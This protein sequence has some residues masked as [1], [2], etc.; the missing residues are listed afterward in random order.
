[1][2]FA[3]EP[4]PRSRSSFIRWF[5]IDDF[6]PEKATTS[7][8]MSSKAFF[9]IRFIVALYS[10]IVMWIDIGF[11]AKVGTFQG[12]FAFFTNMT[13]IGL[14]AYLIVSLEMGRGANETKVYIY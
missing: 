11:S 9:A 1:M 2:T 12:F 14:H 10:T 6:I 13:F 7:Y 4:I 8:W 5:G 3:D